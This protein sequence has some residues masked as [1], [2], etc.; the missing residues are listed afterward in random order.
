LGPPPAL[1]YAMP[2]R[3]GAPSADAESG[4]PGVT[5]DTQMDSIGSVA[6]A[7]PSSLAEIAERLEIGDELFWDAQHLGPSGEWI[8]HIPFALWLVR[9]LRPAAVVAQ[10]A[11]DS[12]SYLALCQAI[13]AF[14][15]ECRAFA[16]TPPSDGRAAGGSNADAARYPDPSYAR[17]STV[18]Q[19][20]LSQANSHFQAGSIDLLHIDGASPHQTARQALETL[21]SALSE[22]SVV[23]IDNTAPHFADHDLRQ[24]WSELASSHPH[25]EFLHEGG[26][27]VLGTGKHFP[28]PVQELFALAGD[29]EGVRR[30]RSLFELSGESLALRHATLRL[31]DQLALRDRLY[32]RTRQRIKE[33]EQA[34]EARLEESGR[35]GHELRALRKA[36]TVQDDQ[37]HRMTKSASWRMTAPLRRVSGKARRLARSIFGAAGGGIS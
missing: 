9:A 19:L 30:V 22:R 12:N 29:T 21:S 20:E 24:L 36:L 34:L 35:M 18:L 33:L 1:G 8:G 31:K 26:L 23:L 16:V 3:T 27:G 14:G 37:I 15:L 5:C 25:F 10:R 7:E 11:I 32:S 13:S 4:G 2:E 17:F 6:P 28:Q